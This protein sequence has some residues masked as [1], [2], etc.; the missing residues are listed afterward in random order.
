MEAT[1]TLALPGLR[2]P[3]PRLAPH[4]EVAG[5]KIS[6]TFKAYPLEAV[7]AAG[8]VRDRVGSAELVLTW[9]PKAETARATADGAAVHVQRHWWL[10]WSEFYPQSELWRPRPDSEAVLEKAD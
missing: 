3:D 4:D 10:A 8:E 2:K 1:K 5:V 9:D 7:R 6:E